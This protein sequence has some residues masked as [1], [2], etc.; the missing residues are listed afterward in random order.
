LQ[1]WAHL[2]LIKTNPMDVQGGQELTVTCNFDDVTAPTAISF[3]N[4]AQ[5]AYYAGGVTVLPGQKS[6]RFSSIVP[7][8]DTRTWL[9]IHNP[10][11]DGKTLFPL[12]LRLNEILLKVG[13]DPRVRLAKL[14][15]PQTDEDVQVLANTLKELNPAMEDVMAPA[16]ENWVSDTLWDRKAKPQPINP[17]SLETI[18]GMDTLKLPEV[19]GTIFE[20]GWTKQ[21]PEVLD[22]VNDK[23]E[24]IEQKYYLDPEGNTPKLPL[25]AARRKATFIT[26]MNGVWENIN[27]KL[28]KHTRLHEENEQG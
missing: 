6:V 8:R 22:A 18:E 19:L 2:G 25:S 7:E 11:F 24:Q 23:L 3:I 28:P 10:A 12:G 26:K 5:N 21:A 14:L 9:L 17:I 16:L 20:S 1:D 4:S 13:T 15:N 27:T